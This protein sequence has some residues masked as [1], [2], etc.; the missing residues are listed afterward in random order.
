[1]VEVRA[2]EGEGSEGKLTAVI[3]TDDIDRY[4]SIIEPSGGSF[5]DYRANPVLQYMHGLDYAV[6]SWPVGRVNEIRRNAKQIEVDLEFDMKGALHG[7]Q[8]KKL[9]AELA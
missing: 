2:A 9:G 6:G 5:D 1:D 8:N 4:Q 7:D 3:N